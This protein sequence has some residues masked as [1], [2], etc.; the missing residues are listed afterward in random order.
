M[1]QQLQE[2]LDGKFNGVDTKFNGV[3]EHID[4]VT[5]ILTKDVVDLKVSNKGHSVKIEEHMRDINGIGV[6][7]GKMDEKV[8]SFEEKKADKKDVSFVKWITVM[9]L[10]FSIIITLLV[11]FKPKLSTDSKIDKEMLKEAVKDLVEK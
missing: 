11:T 1:D 10:I 6:K 7:V 8:D 9:I 3:Y 5:G 4:K 2:Y